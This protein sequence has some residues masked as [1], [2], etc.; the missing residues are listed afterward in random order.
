[1]NRVYLIILL[2]FGT[3]VAGSHISMP[4][5]TDQATLI[6]FKI[7][8]VLIAAMLVVI[9]ILLS[10]IAMRKKVE[11]QLTFNEALLRLATG[12]SPYA[13]LVLNEHTGNILYFN[14]QFCRTWSLEHVINQDG[15][16]PEQ[17][18]G[19]IISHC[20]AQ[21]AKDTPV[22]IE[23][24]SNHSIIEDEVMLLDGRLLRRFS[25]PIYNELKNYYGRFY[26]F[27]D[28]TEQKRELEEIRHFSFHDKVT[29]LYNR[30]YFEEQLKRLDTIRQLPLSIILGD[31]NGL[32][33]VNDTFGHKVGD[34]LLATLAQI[35]VNSCR[36]ED[37]IARWGGDEFAILLP[38]T[39]AR[40]T[41]KICRRITKA[42]NEIQDSP[43]PI[44]IALGQSTKEHPETDMQSVIKA[45]E[46]RM[47]QCK[48]SVSRA[49]GSTFLST[50]IKTMNDKTYD[51]EDHIQRLKELALQV[52]QSF[53]L[54]QNELNNLVLLAELHDIGNVAL[55]NE[56]LNKT[57]SLSPVEWQSIQRHPEI[58]CR[59]VNI[60]PDIPHI[61]EAILAHHEQWDGKGY[62]RG[63]K[64]EE[65]PYI[66]RIL[67]IIHA[68]DV[69]THGRPYQQK[70][71]GVE[72]L[73][74]LKKCAGT[75]FDP[76]LVNA[77]L[78]IIN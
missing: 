32:K 12:S 27:E 70:M 61:A 56:A 72:A 57:S 48:L 15:P 10:N 20:N 76:G 36:Q 42:C 9:A 68:Y 19:N 78:K 8:F 7:L 41:E 5:F 63:L 37:I 62:P 14:R 58:G 3:L 75:Q 34:Q 69:M 29:K 47:Y 4:T 77:F 38:K 16:I 50:L 1:M 49:V 31:A 24:V 33:L 64:G 39:T 28:I 40:E 46:D 18:T 43:I 54:P 73:A 65:I 21:I 2:I 45:A 59:I 6:I 53:N 71:T 55:D 44:S 35:L 66:S 30:A 60:L 74:E 26:I 25:T 52:G 22:F 51:T 17:L 67:A 13:M 11:K 23:T